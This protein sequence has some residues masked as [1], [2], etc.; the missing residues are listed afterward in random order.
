MKRD[1]ELKRDAVFAYGGWCWCCGE[2]ELA[3][4]TIDHVG[5]DGA[6]HR[7][8]MGNSKMYRWLR[9]NGYPQNGRFRVLCWNCNSGRATN[10]GICPHQLFSVTATSLLILMG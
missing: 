10:G 7:R 9:Q 5:G 4:L 3:F 8:E 1:A 2:T 6:E